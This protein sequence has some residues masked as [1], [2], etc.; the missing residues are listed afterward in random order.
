MRIGYYGGDAGRWSAEHLRFL[1]QLGVHDVIFHDHPPAP[2]TDALDYLDL[3]QLRTQCAELG[4]RVLGVENIVA[5]QHF[6]DPIILGGPERDARIAALAA[7]L[8]HMGRAGIPYFGY[9]WMVPPKRASGHGVLRT[10]TTV[11]G[12]GGA[13]TT[14]FDLALLRDVPLFRDREYGDEELW[15]NYAYF[16]H[17]IMPV[18]EEAGV[19]LGLHPHDPPLAQPIGGIPRLFATFEGFKRALEI[20]DSPNWGLTFCLGNWALMGLDVVEAALRYFGERG[21]INYVHV[22]AV[23]GTPAAFTECFFEEGDGDLFGMLRILR[24]VGFAGCLVP[25]HFPRLSGE[26]VWVEGRQ[27]QAY[28]I[29]YVHALLQLLDRLP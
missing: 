24:E 21:R 5:Q 14:S 9:H 15:A 12:R 22:Q 27:G 3:V 11:P 1:A 23:R 4:L 13:L 19:T 28:G 16:M 17:A 18:A 25:S 10:S 7:T 20:A 26:E 2:D 29:G 8:R 6:Y